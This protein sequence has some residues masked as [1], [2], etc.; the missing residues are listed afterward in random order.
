[1]ERR[2]QRQMCI[3]DRH[4]RQIELDTLLGAVR[5]MGQHLQLPTPSM[6]ALYG[7]TRLMARTRGLYPKDEL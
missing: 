5:A 6:D 3:R 1:V 7:L 4:E 2:R